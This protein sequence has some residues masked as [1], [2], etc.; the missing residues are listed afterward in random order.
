[1]TFCCSSSPGIFDS[2]SYLVM[3]GVILGVDY[4]FQKWTWRIPRGKM[5]RLV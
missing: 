4:D 5:V 1:M 3:E 2:L